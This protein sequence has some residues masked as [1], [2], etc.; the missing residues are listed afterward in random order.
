VASNTE[1]L[2]NHNSPGSIIF[3][4]GPS[5]AAN[6]TGTVLAM[7]AGRRDILDV[8]IGKLSLF[9]PVNPSKSR[10]TFFGINIVLVH[11]GHSACATADTMPY[12]KINRFVHQ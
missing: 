9:N 4:D 8:C 10:L 3:D 5:G 11:A 12:I 2:G 1:F 6:H 7:H